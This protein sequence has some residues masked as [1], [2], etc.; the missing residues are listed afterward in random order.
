MGSKGISVAMAL[1]FIV[2]LAGFTLFSGHS[3]W[4][5]LYL[6]AQIVT[7]VGYGDVVA[8]TDAG[9]LFLTFFVLAS[10][11]LLSGVASAALDKFIEYQNAALQNNF[12]SLLLSTFGEDGDADGVPEF[13][14][15]RYTWLA[16]YLKQRE[17]RGFL[18]AF[19]LWAL[20]VFVGVAFFV[21]VPGEDQTVLRALYMS[22]IT[23]STVGFG[24]ATPRTEA[25]K[26][27]AT[28]WML[29]GTVALANMV[30]KFSV[31]FLSESA[32]TYGLPHLDA[33]SLDRIFDD[34]HVRWSN[35]ARAKVLQGGHLATKTVSRTDFLVFMIKDMG[36]VDADVIS[37]LSENFDKLDNNQNGYLDEGDFERVRSRAWTPAPP[38]E[39]QGS[40]CPGSATD[41]S[42]PASALLA[43]HSSKHMVVMGGCCWRRK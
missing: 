38:P 5:S 6:M 19:L 10:V 4:T 23:L 13:I 42:G 8:T 36:L 43:P 11:L 16:W 35:K 32:K 31:A 14:E 29:V 30:A 33:P 17:L 37:K 24:D 26:A 28:V 39:L 9:Y 20:C 15:E 25:G 40:S 18:R 2:G 1:W 34:E 27:F 41:S 7:T 12:D 3:I 22:V 21:C